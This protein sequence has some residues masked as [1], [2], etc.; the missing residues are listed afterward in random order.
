MAILVPWHFCR[1]LLRIPS[2]EQ[3]LAVTLILLQLVGTD[4]C[5]DLDQ[6]ANGLLVAK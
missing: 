1:E 3:L 5:R 6:G 2:D 4:H